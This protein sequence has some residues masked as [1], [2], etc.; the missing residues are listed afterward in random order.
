MEVT[1]RATGRAYFTDLDGGNVIDFQFAPAT[2]S[3]FEGSRY[4]DRISIGEYHTDFL[5]LSGKPNNFKL[6]FWVDRTQESM[7]VWTGEDPFEN[8][9]NNRMRTNPRYSNFD[10]LNMVRNMAKGEFGSSGFYT[11][12]RKKGDSKKGNPLVPSK[13]SVNPDFRQEGYSEDI[14]VY[15]DLEKLLHFVRPKGFKLAS[16]KLNIDGTMR[17]T[18]FEQS[19]F[20]P[21]PKIRFYYGNMWREGYIEQVSY[22]LSVMNKRLVPRRL[23]ADITFICTRWGY[24]TGL[25]SEEG[26]KVNI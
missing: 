20:T 26:E 9:N 12:L 4:T 7:G 8:M 25:S 22:Q 1:E 18:D 13:Y 5:W 15:G 6:K 3:M 21:P 2:L 14:G 11:S 24:L 19:R 16:I 23:E 17:L 10:A